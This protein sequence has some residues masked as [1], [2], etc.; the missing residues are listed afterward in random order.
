MSN[1]VEEYKN[2]TFEH[3]KG[4]VVFDAELHYSGNKPCAVLLR[5]SEGKQHPNFNEI[6]EDLMKASANGFTKLHN[7]RKT[8]D[9]IVNG[10]KLT[11]YADNRDNTHQK[12]SFE[13]EVSK[14]QHP[15]PVQENMVKKGESQTIHNDAMDYEMSEMKGAGL[16]D[17]Q[18]P[19][20]SHGR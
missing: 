13:F 7:E 16:S 8:G 9:P 2:R 5:E 10:D 15:N 6:K 18:M 17:Y 11:V 14:A 4:T 1:G 12:Q 20:P 3:S 19:S